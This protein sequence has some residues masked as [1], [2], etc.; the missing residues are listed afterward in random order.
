[1]K[2]NLIILALMVS[3]M[4]VLVGCGP[5]DQPPITPSD[6]NGDVV[7]D[8]LGDDTDTADDDMGLG[9]DD[10]LGDFDV[11][12]VGD[13]ETLDD[14][15]GDLGDEFGEDLVG[16]DDLGDFDLGELE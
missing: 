11:S 7:I 2:T 8:D 6:D 5:K 1:V 9:D 13:D 14:L 10:D 12:D 15:F 4:L 16:D 3:A